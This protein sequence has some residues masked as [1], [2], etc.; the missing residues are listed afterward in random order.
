MGGAHRQCV[1]NHYTKIKYKGSYRLHKLGTPK[2]LRTDRVDPLL[3]LCFA[4][5]KQV[6][7]DINSKYVQQIDDQT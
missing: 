5:V 7:I 3:D 6:I 4:K 1:N 2:V